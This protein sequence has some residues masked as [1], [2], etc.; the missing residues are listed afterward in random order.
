MAATL[1]TFGTKRPFSADRPDHLYEFFAICDRN[2]DVSGTWQTVDNR[3]WIRSTFSS[4]AC[5]VAMRDRAESLAGVTL[6]ARGIALH[7]A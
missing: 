2:W 7:R 1:S 3:Q 6:F 5:A 4:I